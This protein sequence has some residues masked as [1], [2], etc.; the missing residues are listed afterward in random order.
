MA[1]PLPVGPAPQNATGPPRVL[2]FGAA[3]LGAA[4]LACFLWFGANRHEGPAQ[5]LH[6]PFGPSEQAYAPE[7]HVENVALSRA[8]NYLHQ[9]VTT[10]KGDL[11]N[12][13]GRSLR[14]V[15]LN[16]EFQDQM[17]QVVLRQSFISAAPQPIPP[18]GLREIEISFEHIPS[19]WNRQEPVIRVAGLDFATEK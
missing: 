18:R 17:Q 12:S 10:V 6:L 1:E 9:E 15:E 2:L 16:I 14:R 13:G 3:L 11:V 4:V 19:S 7:I 8:E 5:V